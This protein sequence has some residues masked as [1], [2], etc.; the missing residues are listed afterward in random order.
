MA[1]KHGRF[2]RMY[3][4]VSSGAEAHP[5]VALRRWTLNSS[6]DKSETTAQGDTSKN[7]VSGLPDAQG[8]YEGFYDGDTAQA[9]AASQD[10]LARKVYLYPDTSDTT[11]YAFGTA[12]LDFSIDSPVDGATTISGSFAA[13]TPFSAVGSF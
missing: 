10:G 3:F 4:A 8:S 6:T 7:Y 1:R 13:A 2:G 9:W 11:T 12:F 5:A